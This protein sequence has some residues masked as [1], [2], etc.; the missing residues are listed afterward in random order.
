MKKKNKIEGIYRLELIRNNNY[1]GSMHFRQSDN[2]YFMMD[3]FDFMEE[4]K[5]EG[6]DTGYIELCDNN[7]FDD[8]EIIESTDDNVSVSKNC[9]ALYERRQDDEEKYEPFEINDANFGMPFICIVQVYMSEYKCESAFIKIDDIDEI[10]KKYKNMIAETLKESIEN[11]GI[12]SIYQTLNSEDFCIVIRSNCIQKIYEAIVSIMGIKTS[13]DRRLFFTYS[14]IGIACCSKENISVNG[15]PN[16]FLNLSPDVISANEDVRFSIRFKVETSVVQKVKKIVTQSKDADFEKVNGVFGRYD[17]VI[18]MDIDEFAKLYPYL[19]RDKQGYFTDMRK[20]EQVNDEFIKNQMVG[21]SGEMVMSELMTEEKYALIKGIVE[22]IIRGNIRTLNSRILVNLNEKVKINNA[23]DQ[24]IEYL[25]ME[26][27]KEVGQD[28]ETEKI[29]KKRKSL[30]KIYENF[31][32]KYSHRFLLK[33]HWHGELKHMLER[34]IHS[35]ENL[36]YEVDS[37]ANWYVC[38]QYL[39]E[40]FDN[41][42]YFMNQTPEGDEKAVNEFLCDFQLFINAFEKYTH[43]L[44]G[45]NQHTAQA[46]HYHVVAPIDGQKFLIAYE[47]YISYIHEQYRCRNWTGDGNEDICREKRPEVR[48]LVYPDTSFYNVEIIPILHCDVVK[49]EMG[50][51]KQTADLSLCR[52]PMF[53]YFMRPYDLIPLL[54][55][56]I[57]HQMLILNRKIRNQFLITNILRVIGAEFAYEVQVL[58]KTEKRSVTYDLMGELLCKHFVEVVE[59]AYKKKNPDWDK[60]VSIH[61]PVSIKG[62]MKELLGTQSDYFEIERQHGIGTMKWNDILV[63]FSQIINEICIGSCKEVS[64]AD[65]YTEIR[66]KLLLELEQVEESVKKPSE[67]R[68]EIKAQIQ[69]LYEE[70]FV[71]INKRYIPKEEYGIKLSEFNNKKV[72]EIEEVLLEYAE[73]LLNH[74]ENLEDAEPKILKE[75]NVKAYLDVMSRLYYLKKNAC[76]KCVGEDDNEL[77]NIMTEFAKKIAVDFRA[78]FINGSQYMVFDEDKRE[79]ALNLEITDAEKSLEN[80]RT[81]LKGLKINHIYELIENEQQLYKEVCSDLV[82]C[83]Y[84]GLTSFGYFRMSVSLAGG[85]TDY[86]IAEREEFSKRRLIEVISVLL[87][88]EGAEVYEKIMKGNGDSVFLIRIS[89]L[90]EKIKKC[91]DNEILR[92]KSNISKEIKRKYKSDMKHTKK[93]L[94]NLEVFF[95]ILSD[96]FGLIWEAIENNK[97]IT[98]EGTI[99]AEICKRESQMFPNKE[100]LLLFRREINLF[101]KVYQLLEA[102][103]EIVKKADAIENS[104]KRE[105]CFKIKTDYWHHINR[106]YE[107]SVKPER[108]HEV[109]QRVVNYYNDPDCQDSDRSN[110]EKMKDMLQFTQDF[111]YYNRFRCQREEECTDEQAIC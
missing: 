45:M 48:M 54:S 96:Q 27:N 110:Y 79:K 52:I 5:L 77:T 3:Y 91:V 101:R 66:N 50:N 29:T 87:E 75:S 47:E 97:A 100:T 7:R 28:I 43:L 51:E 108:L 19:C 39:K 25:K 20:K 89:K 102:W 42:I 22:E 68:E 26:I 40:L 111:Y 76:E 9:L 80:Y 73:R 82:M 83:N 8:I 14:N 74:K 6:E 105:E 81:A 12:F 90:G 70:L 56:E 4:R 36:A 13:S 92:A 18:R 31:L 38:S 11:T 107:N 99:C 63:G 35:Y 53:E 17:L 44:H 10:L 88:K 65:E 93:Q 86:R 109:V 67:D 103:S 98:W 16:L 95:N 55:H 58:G 33:R 71:M 1:S 104:G 57:G 37:H 78:K 61:L 30:M 62:F 106:V 24:K 64:D 46:P 60:Y 94:E 34:L 69:I 49:K 84:L 85:L 41:M 72:P 32:E 59:K 21:I 15:V 23:S 2:V